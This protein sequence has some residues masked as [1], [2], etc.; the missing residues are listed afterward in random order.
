MTPRLPKFPRTKDEAKAQVALYLG[1]KLKQYNV[2]D[3]TIKAII[4]NRNFFE[5][6]DLYQHI[7][8]LTINQIP[9]LIIYNDVNG[10]KADNNIYKCGDAVVPGLSGSITFA[11]VSVSGKTVI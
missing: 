6:R 9:N 10:K 2:S 4:E 7:P 1:K 5:L 11:G 8:Y 3:E